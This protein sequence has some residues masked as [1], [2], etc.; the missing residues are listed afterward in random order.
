MKDGK[1]IEC[2]HK[3]IEVTDTIEEDAEIA[4]MVTNLEAPYVEHL[5]EK[6]GETK[7]GLH[8]YLRL[9]TPMDNLL[10]ESLL[11]V[12]NAEIAFSNGC[13]MVV[14]YNQALLQC[15]MCGILYRRI[16]RFQSLNEL[17]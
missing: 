16:H 11:D 15:V 4:Q 3:L 10:L 1:I 9:E 2:T 13:V 17:D 5:N 12:T 7:I 8:R 14:P 6:V